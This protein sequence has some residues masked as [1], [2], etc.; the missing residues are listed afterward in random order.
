VAEAM[1]AALDRRLDPALAEDNDRERRRRAA[2]AAE[3][4]SL[5]ASGRLAA[6]WLLQGFPD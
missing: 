2:W 4:A 1:L 6:E 3:N 5:A